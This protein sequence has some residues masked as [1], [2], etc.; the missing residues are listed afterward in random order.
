M[1]SFR[2]KGNEAATKAIINGIA[3]L[4]H[5]ARFT[6]LTEDPDY[7]AICAFENKRVYFLKNPFIEVHSGKLP[8]FGSCWYYRLID[9]LRISS[10][11]TRKCMEAIKRS[12]AV[13]STDDIFSSTYGNLLSH[14]TQL[15]A[16]ACFGKPTVLVG[17]SIG[18][19]ETEGEY[20]AFAK[21]MEHVQLVTARESISL[22]YLESMRLKNT[23]IELTADPAF[24]LEPDTEK[25]EKIYATYK[26]PREKPLVGI[27]PSQGITRYSRTN[28]ENHFHALQQLILFLTQHLDCHVILIPHAHVSYATYD[29]RIFCESL[30][31]K[32]S[33]PEEVTVMSL[34]HS[35]EEIR[36][37]ASR[38]DFMI[39]ERMHAAIASLSQDVPTFVIGYSIKAEGILGDIFGFDSLKDY[40]IPVKKIDEA[41]LEERVKNLFDRRKEVATA[42]SKTMPRIKE[43]ARRNFTLIMETLE[44]QDR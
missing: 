3:E 30:Y 17:H 32:M 21:T 44:Q 18:P 15:R 39:A 35:A 42:L 34:T 22:R 16:T 25:I 1:T 41:R 37:M 24:C 40:L 6:I 10:I 33:F 12:D 36:A 9:R 8:F 38:L 2:N 27:A 43:N 26:I 7:D 13:L 11:T 14:L 23:R 5:N 31:R 19:F 4:Q 28:Y 20:K 29:D